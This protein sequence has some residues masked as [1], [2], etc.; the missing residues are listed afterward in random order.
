LVSARLAQQGVAR[1]WSVGRRRSKQHAHT[2]ARVT[3]HAQPKTHAANRRLRHAA[4]SGL[5][6]RRYA[7]TEALSNHM[8]L[9]LQKTNIIRDYLVRGLR[10]AVSAGS[11]GLRWGVWRLLELRGGLGWP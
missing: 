5:E 1:A 4:S 11:M 2:Q 10:G 9:F 6:D 7:S 3:V 8:G